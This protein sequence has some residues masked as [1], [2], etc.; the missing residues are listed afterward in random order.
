MRQR[1]KGFRA[2]LLLTALAA[3]LICSGFS[4]AASA[5]AVGIYA[6]GHETAGMGSIIKYTYS[7]ELKADASYELKSYFV[8]GDE[9]YEFIETGSYSVDGSNLALTPEGEDTLE[10]TVNADGSITVPVKPSAM[11]RQRT[12]STL[13]KVENPAAGVYTA[14]MQGAATVK[15]TLY[16]DY[17]GGYYYLAV[18]DNGSEPVHEQGFYGVQGDVITFTTSAGETFTGKLG[19][20][21][22][23]APF[24]VAKMMGM[25]VEIQL[26]K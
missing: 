21:T 4:S 26:A 2:A 25:R 23:S 20:N 13:V 10:G 7:L 6:G 11:A 15:A 19:E 12:T 18:P 9:L 16:L 24:V 1:R 8:M 3:A 22:I 17:Q 5:E 14:E